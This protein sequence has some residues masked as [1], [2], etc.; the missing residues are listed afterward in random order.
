[1]TGFAQKVIA[2]QKQHGRHTLPWQCEDPYRIWLSEIML[3]QTQVATVIPYFE[4]FIARFPTVKSLAEADLDDVLALWGGL[5]YY[6]R[7]R[8][9]HFAANQIMT[10]FAGKFPQTRAQLETLKGVGRSTAAAIAV[11]AF[12]K[13]EAICDGNV[14]RVFARHQCLAGDLQKTDRQA[15]LWQLAEARLPKK[16]PI[17]NATR[18]G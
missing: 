15:A 7:A 6:A 4:R 12:G 11:F 10:Q 8:N 16:A 18:R 5:G 17:C 13:R 2:W 9:L 1:M 3:Q 14:R